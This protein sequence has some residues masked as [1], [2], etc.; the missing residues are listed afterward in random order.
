MPLDKRTVYLQEL[1]PEVRN[2]DTL[3][4]EALDRVAAK[5]RAESFEEVDDGIWGTSSAV[6]TNGE[7]TAALGC[8]A[9]L[10]RNNEEKRM[11]IGSRVSAA[12][13]ELSELL[14]SA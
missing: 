7:V 14:S 13:A 6:K 1:D 9:P 8:A 10:Y 5:G 4:D 2:R 11:H 12:A 3:S